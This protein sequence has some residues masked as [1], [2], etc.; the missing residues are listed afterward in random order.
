MRS[1]QQKKGTLKKQEGFYNRPVTCQVDGGNKG[2]FQLNSI[3][4]LYFLGDQMT[5]VCGYK[6]LMDFA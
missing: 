2:T 1:K 6:K 3:V 5:T 4:P